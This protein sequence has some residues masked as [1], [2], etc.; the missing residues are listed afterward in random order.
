MEDSIK[1][2]PKYKEI[3]V[4]W[5]PTIPEHWISDKVKHSFSERVEKGYPNEPLL[6]S[7]QTRGV[8]PQSLYGNRVVS[9]QKDLHLLKLVEVDDFVISLRSFQGGIEYGHY[10]GIISSAYTVLKANDKIKTPYF[11]YLANL[12]ILSNYCKLVLQESEK[13]KI[14]TTNFLKR[15]IYRF[16]Q[17]QNKS[18]LPSF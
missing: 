1:P 4:P 15:T 12:S 16:H 8:I 9:A 11:R 17:K 5:L 7:T 3:E 14:L 18:K 10:R 6:S 13:D 2:Y